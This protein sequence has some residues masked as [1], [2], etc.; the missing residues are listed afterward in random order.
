MSEAQ[1]NPGVHFIR[2]A[3]APF[4]GAALLL[5]ERELR[6]LALKPLLINIVLFLVGLPLAV[7]G[8]M[9]LAGWLIG[10]DALFGVLRIVGQV[11]AVLGVLLLTPVLF[12]IVGGIIAGPYNSA[13][14]VAIERLQRGSAVEDD[15]GIIASVRRSVGVELARLGQAMLVYPLLWLLQFV[16]VVGWGLY[17]AASF[18][19]G[20]NLLALDL[21]DPV[22]ERHIPR[23]SER[24]AFIRRHRA[25]YLGFGLVSLL[26][27]LLPFLNLLVMPVCVAGATLLYLE[28]APEPLRG[29]RRE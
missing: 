12:V 7:W 28:I 6:R 4:R 19:F 27:A 10:G 17:A 1:H 22:F 21:S 14:A 26:F 8:A 5:R 23:F 16:P 24:R 29:S 3:T 13:L 2:G 9:S 18:L 11:A 15:A 25:R 20:A